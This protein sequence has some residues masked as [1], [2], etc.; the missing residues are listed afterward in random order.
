M[1]NTGIRWF[2]RRRWEGGDLA[3]CVVC[4][5][6]RV[7]CDLCG[8]TFSSRPRSTRKNTEAAAAPLPGDRAGLYFVVAFVE[9]E[10]AV[11]GGGLAFTQP[12]PHCWAEAGCLPQPRR[13]LA[14]RRLT[15][16][17]ALA[18]SRKPVSEPTFSPIH[19]THASLYWGRLVF[20]EQ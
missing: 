15:R 19:A 11:D 16:N 12:V 20:F 8:F 3:R 13:A 9:D 10:D 14:R 18:C 5:V 4:V 2:E 7:L 1:Q 6:L 17:S